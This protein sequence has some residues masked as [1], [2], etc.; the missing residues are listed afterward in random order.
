MNLKTLLNS[1]ASFVSRNLPAILTGVG[2]GG[3]VA[4][5]FLAGRG[6]LKADECIKAEEAKLKVKLD[7]TTKFKLG[8][9]YFIP[10]IAAGLG[11]AG[12]MVA[13]NRISAKQLATA[14]SVAK[15]TEKILVDNREGVKDVFGEKGLRKLDEKINEKNA[16]KYFANSANVYETGHGGTLCCEGFLTGT[17]FKASRE[18]IGKCVNEFNARLLAGEILSYNEFIQMLIPSIDID[19]LPDIGY[20]FGYNLDV[21]SQLLEIVEDSFLLADGS[22]PGLIFKLREIP[23][24]EYVE[25]Y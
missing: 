8:I 4:T 14:L 15:A 5:A 20:R 23:L 11:T 16:A 17:L 10:A 24:F 6:T 13:S 18:W 12:L 2:I 19:V 7:N 3:L 1:G 9:K 22:A 21:K 25:M